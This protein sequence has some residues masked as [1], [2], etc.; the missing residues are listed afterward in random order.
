[1]D[2]FW[3]VLYVKPRSEKK[4]TDALAALGLQVY[5]PT[6]RLLRQWKDRKKWLEVPL[7]NGYIF[8]KIA[9]KQRN[10][11]FQEKNVLK[12]VRLGSEYAQVSDS[13]MERIR[14]IS[15]SLTEVVM[16]EKTKKNALIGKRVRVISGL[17]V[18]LE[19]EIVAENNQTVLRVEIAGLGCMMLVEM[20]SADVEVYV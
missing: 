12:Y 20:S 5:V 8:I 11:V 9:E 10:L 1:M 6:Q 19:G 13:E 17:L 16:I 2:D 3:Y 7:F 18:G 4:T 14:T 15:R